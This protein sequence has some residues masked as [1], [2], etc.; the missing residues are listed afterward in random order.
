MR[1]V[2]SGFKFFEAMSPKEATSTT[3]ATVDLQGYEGCTFLV[4]LHS[5]SGTACGISLVS[6]IYFKIQHA[7]GSV[8]TGICSGPD[9]TWSACSGTDVILSIGQFMS[10]S[11]SGDDGVW[12]S[13]YISGTSAASMWSNIY[14][15]GYVGNRRFVRVLMSNSA[16]GDCSAVIP[17]V[18][19]MLGAPANW[20][21]NLVSE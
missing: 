15:V 20:P 17:A 21:V 19:A 16:A 12:L 9:S 1:D 7:Y 8:S 14:A 2:Y 3:G 10:I 5:V 18:I 6:R 4:H 13:L 11:M